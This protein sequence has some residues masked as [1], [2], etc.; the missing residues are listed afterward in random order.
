MSKMTY[1]G[2]GVDYGAMDPFK[3]MAQRAARETAGN[4]RRLNN[5]EFQ[6]V[7]A[8][9]GESVYLIEA[10]KSYFAHVDE[11]LGTKNLVADAMYKLTGKSYYGHVAQCTVAM[12]VNDAITSGALPLSVAMHLA[13]GDS[14]WFDDVKRCR[15]LIE[16][17]KRACDLSRC[18]WGGGETATLKGIIMPEA[19]LLACSVNGLVKP[20]ERLIRAENIQ[21]GDAI[22]LIGSSGVHA[23]GLTMARGVAE[24]LPDGYLT[25]LDD[26]RTYGEA[27]LDPT[28][29]YVGLV[30]DCLN[31][32]VDIHSPT[33]S[34]N[35]LGNCQSSTSYRNTAH[36][37]MPRRSATS[38]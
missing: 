21:H 32:G 12:G 34:S 37:M 23:N 11:G 24:K 13:V 3:R 15:D 5:G 19:S 30:E 4:I 28:Y 14:R 29:I 1:K 33:S 20:K 6:E 10:A 17:W 18:V 27:L 7:E 25:K 22:I 16:G 36:S 9:R 26:G 2:T 31:G 38:T 8:S 35:C